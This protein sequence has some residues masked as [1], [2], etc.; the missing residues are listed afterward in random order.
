MM[1]YAEDLLGLSSLVA[2]HHEGSILYLVFVA[3][4]SVLFW[5]RLQKC[6]PAIALTNQVLRMSI[7]GEFDPLCTLWP[8][9]QAE[10]SL[11]KETSDT[12]TSDW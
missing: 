3:G 4:L 8:T 12:S 5:R 10:R 9:D 7:T 6:I 1:S 2:A 11:E